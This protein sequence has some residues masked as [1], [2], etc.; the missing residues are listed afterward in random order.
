VPDIYQGCELASFSLVDPDNRRPVDFARRRDLLTAAGAAGAAGIAGAAG[1]PGL[2]ELK[3]LVTTRALR[4][5]RARPDWFAGRY[6]PLAAAGLAAEHVL[7]FARAGR[8]VTVA[9]RL[10]AGLRRRGGWSGTTLVMPGTG[11]RRWRALLTGAV[12]AG[13]ALPLAE[14]TGRLPVALL[15][16]ADD[17]GAAGDL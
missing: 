10:P 1:G 4:L 13:P 15:V 5:R 11:P 14:L 7:A 8:A 3:L 17:P 6:E 16:P 12:Y 2:D 9:T